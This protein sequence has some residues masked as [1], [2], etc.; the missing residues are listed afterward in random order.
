VTT[1][2]AARSA[3]PGQRAGVKILDHSQDFLGEAYAAV[4]NC[5]VS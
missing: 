3:R 4:R 1:G 5:A 2:A